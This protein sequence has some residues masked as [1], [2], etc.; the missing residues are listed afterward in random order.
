MR[1]VFTRIFGE[2]G[3]ILRGLAFMIQPMDEILQFQMIFRIELKAQILG[4]EAIEIR[5]NYFPTDVHAAA[6][7]AYKI[8]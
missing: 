2:G 5:P 4:H 7:I 3:Q 8:P 1:L 6:F